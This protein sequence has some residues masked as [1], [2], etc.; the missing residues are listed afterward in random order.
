IDA[1]LAG[2]HSPLNVKPLRAIS[3]KGKEKFNLD[4]RP[5]SPFDEYGISYQPMS[6]L[7]EEYSKWISKG[8]PKTHDIK[9][10]NDDKY[11]AKSSLFVF[12]QMDFVVAFYR[13]KNW[14]YAISQ[15]KKCWTDK[16]IY[17]VFYYLRKKSKL[18]SPNQYRF[19][20]VNCLFKTYINNAQTRYYCNPPDDNLSTHEHMEHGAV[21]STFERLIKNIIN[22]FSIS[23]GLSWHLVNDVYILVNSDEK[24]HWVLVVFALKERPIRVY[25]T[26][27]STRKKVPSAEIKK[28]ATMLPSYIHDSGFLNQSERT[29]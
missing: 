20:T 29:N 19:T 1:L 26:S 2:L 4:V 24:F 5:S 8:F 6:D 14:F 13:D 17:V 3:N 22:G 9:K 11:R 25:D 10:P 28:L 15:P 27:L 23:V 7:L 16:H 12:G 18:H 21:V